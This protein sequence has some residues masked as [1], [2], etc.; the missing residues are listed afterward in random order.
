LER[1]RELGFL[2]DLLVGIETSG[3]KVV[4][5]RG[6]AGIGKSAL[7]EEFLSR[8]DEAAHV[9]IGTCDDLL[10]PQPLGPFWDLARAEPSLAE[11]LEAGDRFQ[12]LRM[13]LD[14][15]TRSLRATILVI[16]DSHWADEATLDA[17]KYLGRRIAAT[18][19]L[20]VLT[21][22]EAEV[23]FDHPLRSVIG[24]LAAPS[25][26]R[27]HLDGLSLSAVAEIV[28]AA[29]WDPERVLAA[30][31]GNPFLV[32][33]LAGTEAG[34]IPVSVQDAVMARIGRLPQPARDLLNTLSVVPEAIPYSQ[35]KELI[36]ERADWLA[37]C[38]RA[39]LLAVTDEF[40]TFTHELIRRAVEAS[41]NPHD[42]LAANRKVLDSLPAEVGAA[43]FVHHAREINDSARL[44]EFAPRAARTAAAVGSHREAVDHFRHLEPLLD[45]LETADRGPLLDDWAQEE[46]QVGHLSEA[47]RLNDLAVQHYRQ[48]GD[49]MA[50]SGAWCRAAHAHELAGHRTRAEEAARRAVAVLGTEASGPQL[51]VALEMNAYLA[52]MAGDFAEALQVG[53]RA[54][55]VAEPEN[56]ELIRIRVLHHR[57]YARN[58]VHYPDGQACYDEAAKRAAAAGFWYEECRALINRGWE[59]EAAWDLAAAADSAQKAIVSAVE[60]EQ[61]VLESYAKALHARVLELQGE[62]ARAEDIARDLLEHPGITQMVALPV[63]GVLEAR[64]GR[65]S[66]RATLEL[67]WE[68]A[69]AA[70]EF[71]RVAPTAIA[72]AEHRWISGEPVAAAAGLRDA[73]EKAADLGFPWY[74]GSLA[75]WLW[76]LGELAELP[77]DL[78]EPYRLVVE[79]DARAAADLWSAI[80]AP[81]ERAIALTHGDAEAR[82]EALRVFEDLQANAVAA[83]LRKSL[84]EEG[85]PVPRGK[86]RATRD[87]A[88][89]LTARQA[90]I[91]HLLHE[92]LSNVEIA[93]RLFLSLRTVEHHVSAVLAKLDCSSRA[94]AV[95]KATRQGLLAEPF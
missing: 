86:G 14:L 26:E 15:L 82:L 90:E 16:E 53:E 89:G 67:A 80:G 3:G 2:A 68:T 83:K 73:L 37:E 49:L 11:P 61:T 69:R 60:H 87:H 22:R 88:A 25:V 95:A 34:V 54:L 50:E 31:Q 84:R 19:G 51:A 36:G 45:R 44:I 13:V 92:E 41:L 52:A 85:V 57:G 56:E 63:V 12:L 78:P 91:L 65:I 8:H 46:A 40:V 5:I 17:V 4:L 1:D 9:L 43:R 27:L 79:G 77:P 93:D 70:N 55:D 75:F 59:S 58:A 29:G 30:T 47:I 6:E 33:Q 7:V 74:V 72:I 81:Y 28:G 71:Q 64:T 62:W 24:D 23:D 35:A 66:A 21:Y 10:I 18:N 32:T 94:D 38:D 48:L 20:L 76:K 39:G 42:R